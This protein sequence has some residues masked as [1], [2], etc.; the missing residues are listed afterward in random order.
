MVEMHLLSVNADFCY[1]PIY[2]LGVVTAFDRFMQAYQ[3]E[4]DRDSIFSALCRS[5][6]G[7][8]GRYQQDA[9]QLR[10]LPEK[11]SMEELIALLSG[12]EGLAVA[13]DLQQ[14]LRQIAKTPNFKYTR[15][16]AIGLFTLLELADASRVADEKQRVEVLRTICTGLN[17]SEDKL[18][19]D[20]D[21]YRSNLEKMAQALS[22]MEDVVSAERKKSAKQVA[23]REVAIASTPPPSDSSE[24]P[25]TSSKD[26]ATS[27]S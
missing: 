24:T 22:I 17:L 6:E 21:L 25:D 12:Q 18:T 5:I 20:L 4:Q 19:K 16:F 15:L 11:L 10:L 23:D 7:D 13:A 14:C 3:P 2:A 27:G 9:Q 8:P 26:E 1:D